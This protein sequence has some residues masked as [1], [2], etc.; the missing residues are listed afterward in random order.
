MSYNNLKTFFNNNAD[1]NRPNHNLNI[2][3]GGMKLGSAYR[4]YIFRQRHLVVI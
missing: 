3:P 1:D 2:F 4:I